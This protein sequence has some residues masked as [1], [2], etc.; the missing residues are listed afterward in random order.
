MKRVYLPCLDSVRFANFPVEGK[1]A[2]QYA[3]REKEINENRDY[4]LHTLGIME[5]KPVCV[6]ATLNQICDNRAVLM[7][8]DPGLYN[9]IY[10]MIENGRFCVSTYENFSLIDYTVNRLRKT[11]MRI[12]DYQ[13]DAEECYICSLIPILG[14]RITRTPKSNDPKTAILLGKRYRKLRCEK[15]NDGKKAFFIGNR[16]VDERYILTHCFPSGD[17]RSKIRIKMVFGYYTLLRL[18]QFLVNK[19]ETEGS[20]DLKSLCDDYIGVNI[21]RIQGKSGILNKYKYSK[22]KG[23]TVIE[24]KSELKALVEFIIEDMEYENSSE[25]IKK[26]NIMRFFERLIDLQKVLDDKNGMCDNTIFYTR[27]NIDKNYLSA[28]IFLTKNRDVYGSYFTRTHMNAAVREVL[29]EICQENEYTN[30]SVCYAKAPDLLKEK[31][32]VRNTATFS[33][34]KDDFYDYIDFAYNIFNAFLAV[35]S[36]NQVIV[37][38]VLHQDDDKKKE[39]VLWQYTYDAEIQNIYRVQLSWENIK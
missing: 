29:E 7:D 32:I 38:D 35:E 18:Y 2:H 12:V 16:E 13:A 14:K 21:S 39:S 33:K 6:V 37:Y 22:G 17:S 10:R 8:E 20:L 23:K 4:A 26:E 15:R 1:S 9:T 36:N 5:T 34:L 27:N 3:E 11:L 28:V 25:H 31:D 24:N 30:R 19:L